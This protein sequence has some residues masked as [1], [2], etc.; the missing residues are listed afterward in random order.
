M[1]LSLLYDQYVYM[2]IGFAV[3]KM[4]TDSWYHNVKRSLDGESLAYR[5][6]LA[7]FQCVV[8][9]V[10]IQHALNVRTPLPLGTRTCMQ[11]RKIGDQDVESAGSEGCKVPR[12]PAGCARKRC[13]AAL[14]Y[15]RC[16]IKKEM[17][18]HRLNRFS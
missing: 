13:G 14:S 10:W 6:V 3:A 7:L 4:M 11:M 5:S 1:Y 8:M 2:Y 18:L 16:R 17:V 15:S 12:G 9:S